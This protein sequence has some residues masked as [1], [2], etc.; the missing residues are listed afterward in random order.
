MR[1]QVLA[2]DVQQVEALGYLGPT[3]GPARFQ[4]WMAQTRV[5][6]EIPCYL[7]HWRIRAGNTTLAVVLGDGQDGKLL[8][9]RP[10]G[11]G[12]YELQPGKPTDR[13]GQRQPC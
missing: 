5:T 2:C 8:L 11:P 12:T 1:V 3:G 9:D 13:T 10:V 6:P 4:A 7:T